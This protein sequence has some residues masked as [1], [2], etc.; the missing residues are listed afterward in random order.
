MDLK[1]ILDPSSTAV[2]V[3]D[4]Q[5]GYFDPAIVQAR[6][7]ALPDNAAQ[8]LEGIDAFIEHA[9]NAGVE[10]VWTKMVEDLDLSPPNIAEIIRHDPDGSTTIAKP[11]TPSF[12]IYGRVKPDP[13]EKVITKYRYNAFSQTD[14]AEY[15]KGKGITTVVLIGGY[16]SRCVLATAAGANGEDMLCVVPTDLVIHQMSAASEVEAFGK[17]INAILG[18]TTSSQEIIT[19]W[20][21]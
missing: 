2:I 6:N 17:V 7:Q 10:V 20:T 1:K 12:E 11:G 5:G 3:I 21:R 14:L 16:T 13:T 15:L 18:A 4:K 19:T 9:R 8:V